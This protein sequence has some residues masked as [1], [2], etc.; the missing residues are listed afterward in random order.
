MSSYMS[1]EERVN[2]MKKRI[3]KH[4]DENFMQLDI[5]HYDYNQLNLEDAYSYIFAGNTQSGKTT[6]MRGIVTHL[7]KNY[8]H[9]N[10]E[11]FFLICPTYHL[12]PDMEEFIPPE[13]VLNPFNDNIEAFIQELKTRQASIPKAQRP[14]I[15][16]IVDDV[17]GIITKSLGLQQLFT[18]GRHY[19]II[20][21]ILLQHLSGLSSPA[22]RSNANYTFVTNFSSS[23]KQMTIECVRDAIGDGKLA[24][25]FVNSA[26]DVP[27]LFIGWSCLNKNSVS[28]K[29]FTIK[30]NDIENFRPIKIKY[31][32]EMPSVQD[33]I[34]DTNH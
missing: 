27:Y 17:T 9:K 4:C 29:L 25:Y 28:R 12:Q 5:P 10:F 31:D 7:I 2:F 1:A 13:M 32:E 23:S 3:I 30:I 24:T 15:L 20:V 18:S 6:L 14:H 19:N 22:I 16:L 8:K 33:V 11:A 34:E 21:C 26:F